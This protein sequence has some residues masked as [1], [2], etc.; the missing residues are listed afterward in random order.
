MKKLEKLEL[1]KLVNAE[2]ESDLKEYDNLSNL[3]WSYGYEG[4]Q[5]AYGEPYHIKNGSFTEDVSNYVDRELEGEFM[6]YY[7]SWQSL[8]ATN[9]LRDNPEDYEHIESEEDK[10][11]G[12][13]ESV[14]CDSFIYMGFLNYIKTC[15]YIFLSEKLETD[16]DQLKRE[17]IWNC[18][19]AEGAYNSYF[20]TKDYEEEECDTEEIT[21]YLYE[22]E[23]DEVASSI[24]LKYG[25]LA[26]ETGNSNYIDEGEALI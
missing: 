9:S 1:V 25:T 19:D 21:D 14:D 17:F 8:A 5:G 26:G 22:L 4:T 12:A 3:L 20:E 16:F 6:D 23:N 15:V 10:W 7:Y 2:I 13:L 11:E 18:G 24:A